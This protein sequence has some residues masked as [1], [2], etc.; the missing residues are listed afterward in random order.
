MKKILC[1]VETPYRGTLEEQD[2][3]TLWFP[4][5]LKN[6]GGDMGVLLRGNAVNYAVAA[7]DPSG[8]VIWKLSIERPV[9]PQKD[10]LE[11]KQA[12]IPVRVVRDDVETRGISLNSLVQ[13]FEVVSGS[14]LPSLFSQYDQVLALVETDGPPCVGEVVGLHQGCPLLINNIAKSVRNGHIS[15]C[16]A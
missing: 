11:M 4:H 10:L 16:G 14:D 1:I 8:V 3:A 15:G 5:A 7:Q 6:A 2:D 9:Y 13:D 12:G